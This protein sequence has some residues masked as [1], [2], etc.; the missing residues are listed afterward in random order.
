M[1]FD[2]FSEYIH[3]CDS[4]GQGWTGLTNSKEIGFYDKFETVSVIK[5]RN[6][7]HGVLLFTK[8]SIFFGR[9]FIPRD[10]ETLDEKMF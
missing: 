4:Y 8:L 2:V 7:E 5:S 6:I 3:D 10:I 9:F 1:H